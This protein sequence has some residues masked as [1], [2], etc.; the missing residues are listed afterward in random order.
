MEL[1]KIEAIEIFKYKKNKD[2]YWDE[3]KLYQ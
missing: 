1:L 2:K 3:A